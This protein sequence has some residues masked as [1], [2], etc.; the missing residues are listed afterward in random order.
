MNTIILIMSCVL[1]IACGYQRKIQVSPYEGGKRDA[2]S[3]LS[4]E[5]YVNLFTNLAD[6]E[7]QILCSFVLFSVNVWLK[8]NFMDIF[9]Y[10]KLNYFTLSNTISS[11]TNNVKLKCHFSKQSELNVGCYSCIW[12]TKIL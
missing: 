10:I 1:L 2:A 7:V 12:Q 4:S 8:V 9:S 6:K 3:H 5:G 11:Y